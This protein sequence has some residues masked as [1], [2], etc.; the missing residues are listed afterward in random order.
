[1]PP[2]SESKSKPSKN[3]VANEAQEILLFIMGFVS[4]GTNF[5]QS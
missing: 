3:Q 5:T 4:E 1:M 2:S